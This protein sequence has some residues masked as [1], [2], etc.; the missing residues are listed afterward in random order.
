MACL[1]SAISSKMV[2]Q[3]FPEVYNTFPFDTF[4]SP[5]AIVRSF[6]GC[7][8]ELVSSLVLLGDAWEETSE[9]ST[10]RCSGDCGDSAFDGEEFE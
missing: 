7:W 8:E 2:F 1:I 10:V 4:M 6:I 3:L 5:I 9:G